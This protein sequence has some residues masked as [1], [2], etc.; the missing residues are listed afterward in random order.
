MSEP[1]GIAITCESSSTGSAYIPVGTWV[2]PAVARLYAMGY[3]SDVYQ[4][5][6]PWTRASVL[7]MLE[8]TNDEIQ[9]ADM[10]GDPTLGEAQDL[11][12]DLKHELSADTEGNCLPGKGEVRI[13]ST[14]T[15]FRG[16][17]GTP[18]RDSYHLGST[19]INDYGRRYANGLNNYSGASGYASAGPFLLYMRGEFQGEPST[20]PYSLALANQLSGY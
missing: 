9:D 4:G 12:R 7:H 11:Y 14:Y 5:M 8:E 2:Y 3:A 20:A 16:I 15:V 6:R 19:I 18:L 17:S 13:E 10:Y 1:G